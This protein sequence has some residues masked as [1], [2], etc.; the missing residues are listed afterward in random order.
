MITATEEIRTKGRRWR[1]LG[2]DLP[3]QMKWFDGCSYEGTL[4][5]RTG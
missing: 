4:V 2:G 3:F 1:E 5:H